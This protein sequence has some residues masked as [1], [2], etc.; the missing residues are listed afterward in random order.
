MANKKNDT[1]E[2]IS[3][4][5]ENL[6]DSTEGALIENNEAAAGQLSADTSIKEVQL[7]DFDGTKKVKESNS[8]EILKD[9]PLKLVVELGKSVLKISDFMELGIGSIIEL[10]KL[11]GDPL[12]ILVNNR[13]IGRGEVV[14]IDEDFAIRVTE[15]MQKPGENS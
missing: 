1:K 4:E 14:V 7:E 9:V 10:D 2:K 12:D 5:Q 13:L 3:A 11:Y 15:I 6:N 8:F